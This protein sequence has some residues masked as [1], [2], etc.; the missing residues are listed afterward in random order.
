[1]L[2]ITFLASMSDRSF[3][4]LRRTLPD[5]ATGFTLPCSYASY[6]GDSRRQTLAVE[7]HV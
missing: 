3:L 6:P 7:L 4:T 2:A 1:M 5:E